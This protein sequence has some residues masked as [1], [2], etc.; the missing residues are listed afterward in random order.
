MWQMASQIED[1]ALIGDCET[2]ALV[3]RDGSIDWLSFPRFDSAACFAA[4][5]NLRN[6]VGL[7][8][9]RYDPEAR[10]MVGNFSQAF[11]HVGLINNARNLARRGGPAE[12]RPHP[13]GRH[14]E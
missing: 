2:V 3:G 10:R 5:P 14:A 13:A 4:P 12:D 6:D 9:E 8:S 1:Y 7:L 11:S